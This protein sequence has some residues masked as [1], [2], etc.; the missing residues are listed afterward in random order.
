MDITV[1]AISPGLVETDMTRAWSE[2]L[3]KTLVQRIPKGRF[4]KPDEIAIAA[5]FLASPGARFITG[6]IISV[7]GGD[8]MGQ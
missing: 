5:V 8:Y 4:A 2:E 1:N 6:Q 7:N 3:R